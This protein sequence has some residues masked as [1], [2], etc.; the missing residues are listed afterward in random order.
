MYTASCCS[1]SGM[2]VSNAVSGFSG[3]VVVITVSTSIGIC[4]DVVVL[5]ELLV[6]SKFIDLISTFSKK[7]SWT[8]ARC[9]QNDMSG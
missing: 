2:V 7:Y 3:M 1:F 9:L 6:N 4:P 5:V 8:A